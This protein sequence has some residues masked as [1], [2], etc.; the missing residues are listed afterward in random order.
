MTLNDAQ[1]DYSTTEKEMLV[2]LFALEK[3][4][5]YLIRCKI[6]VLTDHAALKYLITKR[7]AKTRLIRWVLLLQERC[8]LE[9]KDKKDTKN[10]VADHLSRLHFDTITEPLTLNESFP[11]EQL[12]SLEVLPW[13]A[14]IVNYVVTGQL[15]EYWTKQDKVNFFCRNK[16]FL[17][18]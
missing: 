17:L 2:V 7:D 6:I 9:F 8:Y 18:G 5:S 12:M 10:I 15:P 13:Y 11:D 14:D 3:F 16:E 1:L 4:R